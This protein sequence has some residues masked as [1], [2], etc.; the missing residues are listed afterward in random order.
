MVQWKSISG[1]TPF[2]AFCFHFKQPKKHSQSLGKRLWMVLNQGGVTDINNSSCLLFNTPSLCM[3]CLENKVRWR[4]D[5]EWRSESAL[6][7]GQIQ[8]TMK[9]CV[10]VWPRSS[11]LSCL[12]CLL[13]KRS[14]SL[15][16]LTCADRQWLLV[17]CAVRSVICSLWIK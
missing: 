11:S 10:S 4:E 12:W 16:V 8:S 15:F 3:T 7:F 1:H 13:L 6:A 14:L 17:I 5:A 9:K 2:Q